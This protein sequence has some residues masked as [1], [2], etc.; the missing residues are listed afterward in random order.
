MSIRE[1][2]PSSLDADTIAE[3]QLQEE[4]RSLFTVDTQTY[5]EK[6]SQLAQGL[7]PDAWKTDI[8][9]LYRCIHTIKGGA[10]TVAAE[11]VLQ[12]A[13][14][15]E[16]LL[17]EL[18]YLESPPLETENLLQQ[19]L[20][21]AGELLTGVLVQ[22]TT[23]IAPILQRVQT[24]HS[25]IRA[26][27]LLQWNPQRQLHQDFAEHG[28]D[29]VVLELQIDLE[30][31]PAAEWVPTATIETARQ[32]L[33]KLHQIGAELQLATGWTAL[34]HQA[35]ELLNCPRVDV[36]QSQWFLLFQALKT[37]ATQSGSPVML[38]W[39]VPIASMDVNSILNSTTTPDRATA[40][41]D[42]SVTIET[43]PNAISP[44]EAA[45]QSLTA[46]QREDSDVIALDS[47]DFS[48]FLDSEF[49]QNGTTV[50]DGVANNHPSDLDF[51][52][53]DLTAVEQPE[54]PVAEAEPVSSEDSLQTSL[55]PDSSPAAPSVSQLEILP[56]TASVQIPVSLEKLD[57]SA[58]Y[59]VETLLTLRSTHGLYQTLQSQ[60]A[61]L[62]ALAQ[63]GI[64]SITQLRQIQDDYAL[65]DL[66]S[67]QTPQGLNPERYR[68][69]YT[70]INRL[71][72]TNLRLS[73][74]GAEAG[75]MTEQVTDRLRTVD[76][77]VL[78]LQTTIEDSRLVSFQSL[79]IRAKAILRDLVT[80]Y[81]KPARLLVLGEH[82]ELDASTARGLEPVLLHLIRNAYDHGLEPP[83]DRQS[84]GKPEQG[85]I[86]LS[87]RRNGNLFS[88]EFKDDGRG[89]DAEKIQSRAEA[90]NFPFTQTAT[91]DDLLRVICQPGF[92]SETKATEL[93]G[94]GV[95]MDVV[96][97]QIARLGGQLSLQTVLGTGTTFQI[98]F[99]APRLLVPC[100]LL[101][102]GD[103]TFAI[104]N[105]EIRTITLL[106]SLN[107][108]RTEYWTKN[109]NQDLHAIE[110]QEI[111][112][113]ETP[114]N[115]ILD[116]VE[117]WQPNLGN[118]S[119]ADTAIC[120]LIQPSV[121]PHPDPASSGGIWLLADELL[122]Q[123]ELVINPL[124]SPLL[125]AKGLLGV[126]LQ[127][128]GS[129]VPV[130]DPQSLVEW[131][132]QR[133]F[134]Q[135]ES[136]TI[137]PVDLDNEATAQSVQTI[138]I[139][140]DAALMRRRLESSLSANG[141]VI[142]TCADGQEA[143]NWLQEHPHPNLIL[144]DIEMPN[145][146]GFTLIDRCRQ[147]GI[148]VPILVISSRLSEEWFNEAKRL[149]ATDYLT[150]GFATVEL[151][152]KVNKLLRRLNLS[153]TD[154]VGVAL[155][156]E[157]SSTALL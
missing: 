22:N 28:L 97:A 40:C 15:L 155:D 86:V 99:P 19:A 114:V 4:L 107:A 150:K 118:R 29:M 132:Q 59:L 65:L 9:E 104:P 26:R 145:M 52:A 98:R 111:A 102:T 108:V 81:S 51:A 146:D 11:A 12:V 17:S 112:K 153:E 96:M 121:R 147:T 31:L 58:Q 72:E 44:E 16:D 79:G 131:W 92:S 39:T 103:Y 85:T 143:W 78:K 42:S 117:Y 138:L 130:L 30:R 100:L 70:L 109:P 76:D 110:N 57:R 91:F 41:S 24:L 134:Q 2:N 88:L 140:D 80:R 94:R 82:T 157:T 87:L 95:G 63:E 101:R 6:Y 36:W 93:S 74:I 105:D 14:A 54:L 60:I 21:E 128:N 5:L 89:I 49:L 25:D 141:F 61:Q 13:T 67:K 115:P 47:I 68:Q 20:L 43:T 124:P 129:L 123:T 106:G 125:A 126:S 77:T 152:N 18:R 66:Q 33:T 135:A 35:E 64:Q 23:E 46:D 127:V 133:S 53:V 1:V 149:G 151:I 156:S 144:T 37:C 83:A 48:E 148:T 154:S 142:Q 136:A 71:L 119:L 122:E 8:Q 7:K 116:L 56:D 45:Y 139:V 10:V 55:A 90:L 120:L 38:K 113:D 34:L 75:K 32:T 62:V 137:D 50:A 27:Y 3:V 73:E 84:Q 69:G